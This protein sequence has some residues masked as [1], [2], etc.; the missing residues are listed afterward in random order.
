MLLWNGSV[1]K[2]VGIH[3]LELQHRNLHVNFYSVSLQ[4]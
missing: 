2:N 3:G 4:L 1:Q